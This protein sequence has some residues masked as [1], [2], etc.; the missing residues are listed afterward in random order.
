MS[1]ATL[2]LRLGTPITA[3]ALPLFASYFSLLSYRVVALR[4]ASDTFVGDRTKEGKSSQENP[5]KLTIAV[6]AHGNFAEYVPLAI[7]ATAL[8]ELNGADPKI[9]IG[10]LGALF[11]LRVGHVEL[12]VRGQ[13]ALGP[14]RIIG[15]LGTVGYLIG[16]SGYV[17]WLNRGY[18][19]F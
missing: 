13:A 17:A 9:L 15:F 4:V 14:G 19:G 10:A 2:G 18:W 11:A 6:R 5:E 1:S 7:T 12:G 3:T 8:A 16:M